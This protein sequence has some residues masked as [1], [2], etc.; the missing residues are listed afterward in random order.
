MGKPA[1]RTT[2]AV[3]HPLPPVLTPGPGALT[4]VIGYLPAWRGIPLAAV[5]ALQSAKTAADIAVKAAQAATTAAAGTPGLPAAKAAEETVK[6]TV[7][8]AMSSMISAAAA[9]GAD[10][11]AC[12]TPFPVPPHGPGVVIDGSPT[13]LINNLPACRQGDSIL[14]ALGPTNKISMGCMTVQIGMSGGSVTTGLGADVD[15]LASQSSTLADNLR[16]LQHDGWKIRYGE[17]GKGTYADRAAKEIVIDSNDRGN[18]EAIVQGLAHESGHGLYQPDAYV[19]PAGLAK[20][21]Y[22]DRNTNSSLKDEGEATMT[23]S[24]VRKELN[25]AGASDIGMAGKESEKYQEIADK[26]PDPDDRDKARQEIG[27]TFADGENPSTDTS[28]TYRQYYG[29][30]YSDWWDTNVG[31]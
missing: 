14:E 8:A 16:Q 5:A 7:L 12:V 13:V 1:A 24:D 29:K 4:V 10:I 27:D 25:D 19:P 26:Y 3:V 17:A 18:T 30:T 9:G 2:D 6:A 21:E 22:V 15:A 20:Q 23:N 28:K 11:H 31:P